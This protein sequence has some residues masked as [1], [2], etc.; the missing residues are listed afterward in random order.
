MAHTAGRVKGEA[1]SVGWPIDIDGPDLL[2]RL[3]LYKI[4]DAEEVARSA[5]FPPLK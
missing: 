1:Y 3:E 4:F 5:E 2:E